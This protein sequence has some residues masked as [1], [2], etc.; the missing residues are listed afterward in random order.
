[1]SL[2]WQLAYMIGFK[3]WD[4]GI[5]PPE[6]VSIVEGP[7]ALS[8]GRALD[9]GCGTGTNVV[10]LAQHG[11]DATGV[12][13]VRRALRRAHDRATAAGVSPRFIAGD[14]TRLDELEVGSG[15]SLLF[16]L[17]CFHTIPGARRD[18]YAKGVTAA[19]A[20]GATLLLFGFAP[21]AMRPGPRGVTADELR[22]R[23]EG[24]EMVEASRGTDRVETWWY[25]LRRRT[26]DTVER[27]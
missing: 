12:D 22:Q 21:G 6:L 7:D 27:N 4:S 11:W 23:F 14:V 15:Y 18:A 24:W 20:D 13:L 17:G 25:R 10:Y 26:R 3:P 16:D 1:M 8:P 5:S 9:L 2:W 19:A